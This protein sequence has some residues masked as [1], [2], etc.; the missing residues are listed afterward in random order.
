MGTKHGVCRLV[1]RGHRNATAC[2]RGLLARPV[3]PW[4]HGPRWTGPPGP[5]QSAPRPPSA[6]WQGWCC[7]WWRHSGYEQIPDQNLRVW[8]CSDATAV[9]CHPSVT[10][11]PGDL[12]Y[13]SRRDLVC[14]HAVFLGAF[15][16]CAPSKGLDSDS[17]CNSV[18]HTVRCSV[19]R[20]M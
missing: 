16:G 13:P 17:A 4:L 2:A 10:A 20:S 3:T 9:T 15:K 6:S 1:L 5:P 7:D 11:K 8:H 14:Q 18:W 12:E 19:W